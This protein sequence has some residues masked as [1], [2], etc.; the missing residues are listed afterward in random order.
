MGREIYAAMS[1]GI[2]ALKTLDAVSNNLANVN[3]TG[4]KAD[5]PTFRL[6]APEQAQNLN[7]ESA[8]ARLAN[9][10]AVLDGVSTDY[11]QGVLRESGRMSD[12][13]IRGEG[14]FQ[15]QDAKGKNFLTRDGSFHV[16]TEGFLVTRDGLQVQQRGGGG[17]QVGPGDFRITESGEVKV[18]EDT[19]G[20]V[21]VV[22]ASVEN[23]SKAGSNRWVPAAKEPLAE[24]DSQVVQRHLE[25]S[26]VQPVQA[27]TE[28]IAVSRYYEAFQTTLKSS[29][30]LDQKLSSSVGKI[31]Q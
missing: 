18:G 2:R 20:R 1:G 30:E 7:P 28:M 10:Y 27:L 5:R 13:A 4:F 16:S 14:F 8:E 21:A 22:S 26:N 9:A 15:L 6:S 24:L 3:T 23:I 17:I 11:S 19:K 31:N 12:L 29:N 25:S